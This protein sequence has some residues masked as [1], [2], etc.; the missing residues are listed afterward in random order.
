MFNQALLIVS[1]NVVSEPYLET[2]GD[3]N[4]P[5]LT[6]RIAWNSRKFD[7]ATGGWSDANTSYAKVTCWRRLA[8]NLSMCLHKGDSIFL[9]GKLEV[10]GFIGRDGQHKTAVDVEAI[11]LG[12]DLTRG[13]ARFKRLKAD[14]TAELPGG[15]NG[16]MY[17]G[18]AVDGEDEA[19]ALAAM[20][21][22]DSG[23][24]RTLGDG[25]FDDSAIEAMA[26][27][28]ETVSAPF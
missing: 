5:K 12:P 15:E 27:D 16:E 20:A 10:R 22:S 11:T 19:A 26:R 24:G 18:A 9:R 7:A 3:N 2:V 14:K 25:V 1:A 13:V 17:D 21:D 4:I 8:E 28:T 6:M 23:A